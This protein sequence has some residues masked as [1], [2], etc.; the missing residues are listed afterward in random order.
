[1]VAI[2]KSFTVVFVFAVTVDVN[3]Y[4]LAPQGFD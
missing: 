2:D 3:N 4:V 1:M